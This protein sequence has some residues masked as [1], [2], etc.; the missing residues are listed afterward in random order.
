MSLWFLTRKL[1]EHEFK[2]FFFWS[3]REIRASRHIYCPIVICF[4]LYRHKTETHLVLCW[5]IEGTDRYHCQQQD[6]SFLQ[7]VGLELL[8][9]FPSLPSFLLLL[10]NNHFALQLFKFFF[11]DNRF[12]FPSVIQTQV[13]NSL[14]LS[15]MG[16]L[17]LS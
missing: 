10:Q 2:F 17:H 4:R 16:L 7:C 1:S 14:I 5:K 15:L 8:D 12:N 11:F 6:W 3:S 9:F 13:M